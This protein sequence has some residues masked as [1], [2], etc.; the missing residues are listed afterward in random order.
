MRI[1]LPICVNF[2]STC[3]SKN[4]KIAIATAD[5]HAPTQAMIEAFDIEE[6]LFTFI[7]ADDGIRSKPAPD[8]VLTLCERMGV[9]PAHVMVIGD[10]TSN[11]KMARAS[12][13]GLAVGVLSG[14]SHARDLAPFADILIESVEELLTYSPQHGAVTDDANNL[15]PGL[16]PEIA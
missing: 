7:C 2:S 11:L 13:A 12:G 16:N 8:T 1:P 9:E 15:L 3:K 6:Y 5:D 4:L 14:V 10:T